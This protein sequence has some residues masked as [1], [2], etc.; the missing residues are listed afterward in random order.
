MDQWLCVHCVDS[1]GSDLDVPSDVRIQR[2]RNLNVESAEASQDDGQTGRPC[3]SWPGQMKPRKG[4]FVCCL[5]RFFLLFFFF[6]PHKLLLWW[7]DGN[8]DGPFVRDDFKVAETGQLSNYRHEKQA[9][10]RLSFRYLTHKYLK[11]RQHWVNVHVQSFARYLKF[12]TWSER[13]PIRQSLRGQNYHPVEVS[14]QDVAVG[15]GGGVVLQSKI[16]NFAATFSKQ[17]WSKLGFLYTLW[18]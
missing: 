9:N 3:R 5:C 17:L 4:S 2:W 16:T 13:S 1:F 18:S 11:W 10:A 12:P 14:V 15:G 8:L 7:W 6:L